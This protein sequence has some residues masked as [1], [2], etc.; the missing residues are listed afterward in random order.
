MRGADRFTESL[1]ALSRLKDFIP[2][3]H[4]LRPIRAMVS[5]ALGQ[6][7]ALCS[8]MRFGLQRRCERRR[9]EHRPERL[10]RATRLQV[11]YSVRLERTLTEQTRYNLLC[12]WFIGL[13]IED[14]LWM[15]TVFSKNRER[16]I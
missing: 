7:D 14:A 6:M 15:P 11:F 12:R 4:P 13:A 5:Q 10:I 1:L 9:S 8:S 16:L 2:A 3:D